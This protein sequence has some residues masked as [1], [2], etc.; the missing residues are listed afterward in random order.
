ME[1]SERCDKK[2][3]KEKG[4]ETWRD[5]KW[6]IEIRKRKIAENVNRDS[7]WDVDNG[8]NARRLERR[9]NNSDLQERW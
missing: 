6:S 4:F 2:F 8:K 5:R 1:R 3:E 9:N 7:E